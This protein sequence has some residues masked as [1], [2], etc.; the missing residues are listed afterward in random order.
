M[1]QAMVPSEVVHRVSSRNIWI[2]DVQE[3]QYWAQ[4]RYDD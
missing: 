3:L 1:P 2:L 4:N